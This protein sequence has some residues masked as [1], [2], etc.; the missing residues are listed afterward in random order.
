MSMNKVKSTLLRSSGMRKMLISVLNMP[1]RRESFLG[2]V[3]PKSPVAFVQPGGMRANDAHATRFKPLIR[4]RL[5]RVGLGFGLGLGRGLRLG[6]GRLCFSLTLVGLLG[7]LDRFARD[8][9]LLG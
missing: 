2:R 1:H 9:L 4:G 7:L 3:A 6:L 8:E 5:F